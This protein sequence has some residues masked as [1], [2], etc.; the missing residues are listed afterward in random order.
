VDGLR[1]LA[2]VAVFIFHSRESTLPGGFLGVD[3]FFVLSGYLITRLIVVEHEREGNVDLRNFWARRFRRLLPASM[4]VLITV[5]LYTA[6]WGSVTQL[7]PRRGDVMWSLFYVANWRFISTDSDY[8][9]SDAETSPLRHMWSLAVEEQFYFF[10]PLVV[11]VI[12]LATWRLAGT[13]VLL[14]VTITLAL[15][16]AIRMATLFDETSPSRAYFGTDA[17]I[18][19]ILIGAAFGILQ[20]NGLLRLQ[21]LQ[22]P[23]QWGLLAAVVTAMFYVEGSDAYYYGYGSTVFAL[24]CGLLIASL[25]ASPATTAASV[26][27]FHPVNFLGR[28]SYAFYLW[29]WPIILWVAD[30]IGADFLDRRLADLVRFGL[31]VAIAAASLHLLEDP[32]RR[33]RLPY[34]RSLPG[35]TIIATAAAMAVI[36]GMAWAFLTPAADDAAALA[37]ND[38]SVVYCPDEPTPCLQYDAGPDAPLVVTMGDSTSQHLTPAMMRLAEENDFSF[39]QA[40]LG[41]CSLDNRR[42]AGGSGGERFRSVDGRCLESYEPIMS[43]V[44]AADPDV[45]VAVARNTATR[46]VDADGNLVEPESPQHLE[47]VAAATGATLDRLVAETSARIILVDTLPRLPNV[48]CLADNPETPTA[49]DMPADTDRW[50]T[51][52]DLVRDLAERHPD[53]LS[54]ISLLTLACPDGTTCPTILGGIVTSYDGVHFTATFSESIAPEIEELIRQSGTDLGQ[55]SR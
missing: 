19:Q 34:V 51:Y 25:V 1:A 33:G 4:A 13:R 16:S 20:A 38:Q 46:H 27:T 44:I 35:R 42:L 7:L 28:I 32:V 2:V 14:G 54:V 50:G 30:P 36:A 40:G 22:G 41:G 15:A 43:S 53:R 18:H 47:D 48:D 52:N 8:F 49:C 21:R 9:A 11:A 29:H 17:R 55:L 3:L 10:W 5:I 12:M 26:L 24:I 37:A 31:V 23:L 6:V 39:M 45:I